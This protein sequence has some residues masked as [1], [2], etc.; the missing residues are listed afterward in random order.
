MYAQNAIAVN[1]FLG[2]SWNHVRILS[3]YFG[4][5]DKEINQVK[6]TPN[7]Y[8]FYRFLQARLNQLG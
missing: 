1:E 8:M 7:K 6:L 2:K 5:Q 3:A 4:V